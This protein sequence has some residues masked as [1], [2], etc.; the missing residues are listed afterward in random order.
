[1]P[2]VPLSFEGLTFFIRICED[3]VIVM[4]RFLR[5][6]FFRY[7]MNRLQKTEKSAKTSGLK[8]ERFNSHR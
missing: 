8:T 6:Q 5:V 2:L 1:M 3:H 4:V 7:L